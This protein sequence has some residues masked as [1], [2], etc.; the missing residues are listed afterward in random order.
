MIR[1]SFSVAYVLLMAG[2]L[3][4]G[5]PLHAQVPMTGAGS[6]APGGV[7]AFT[8]QG[9]CSSCA[10]SSNV[11][12]YWGLRAF[13]AA[14]RGNA[15]VNVCNSTGGSDVGCGDLSSD[16][17]TGMLVS[18]SIGGI[19]CPGTNCTVKTVYDRSGNLNCGGISCDLTQSTVS[20]RPNLAA[21]CLS[22]SLPCMQWT[23]TTGQG[24]FNT[25]TFATANV[26][27]SVS[28]VAERDSGASGSY[29]AIFRGS[30]SSDS[31]VAYFA[32][33]SNTVVIYCS[34]NTT[35]TASA[36]DSALHALQYVWT[37]TTTATITVDGSAN[38]VNP[39]CDAGFGGF[40]GVTYDIGVN[41]SGGTQVLTGLI[42]EVGLY[43]IGLSSSQQSAVN[44]NQHST[45]GW[46]F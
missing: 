18:G 6:G 14:D 26:P 2:L 19:T 32:N 36:T 3:Y 37:N 46:N 35:A 8:G 34:G 29:N 23:G 28:I 10:A 5:H 39:A 7:V 31:G 1:P 16:A 40:D 41:T 21:N 13:S 42:R 22:G 20:L 25:R 33:S 12:A 9:D 15:L 30:E 43:K 24:L 44:T 17:T 27:V 11:I 38:S 45:S 4:L